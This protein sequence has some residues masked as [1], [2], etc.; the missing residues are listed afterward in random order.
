MHC[1]SVSTRRTRFPNR[2]N[3]AVGDIDSECRLSNAALMIEDRETRSCAACHSEASCA[4]FS[5]FGLVATLLS[6]S[7]ACT[8]HRG[9]RGASRS[10]SA[11]TKSF[12]CAQLLIPLLDSD[13]VAGLRSV[14]FNGKRCIRKFGLCCFGV[15]LTDIQCLE[16]W[17]IAIVS[18]VISETSNPLNSS[19]RLLLQNNPSEGCPT[20]NLRSAVQLSVL[21]MNVT[22]KPLTSINSGVGATPKCSDCIDKTA[23][24]GRPH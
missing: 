19:V 5:N 24:T 2:A 15:Q 6:L 12:S 10:G 21:Q 3:A 11:C 13:Y 8:S 17:S 18:E 14:V 20:G 16:M 9:A 4:S 22:L 7:R 1:G 23:T